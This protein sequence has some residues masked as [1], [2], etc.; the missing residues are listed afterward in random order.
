MEIAEMKQAGK[1]AIDGKKAQTKAYKAKGAALATLCVRFAQEEVRIEEK[2]GQARIKF[3]TDIKAL[4]P[5][6]H[7]EFRAQLR[8]ELLSLD[9]G[10]E[11]L[12]QAG[13]MTEKESTKGGYSAASFRVM[14]SNWMTISVACEAGLDVNEADGTPMKWDTVLAAARKVR[15]D[16]QQAGAQLSDGQRAQG[17]GRKPVS[18]YDKA[19]KA[20]EKLDKRAKVKLLGVLAAALEYTVTA[21]AA[22]PKSAGRIAN[23]AT[24]APATVH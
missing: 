13:A 7:A 19:L 21:P 2:R 1:G 4:T 10:E 22:A 3:V 23:G 20:I 18:D 24:Q 11:L 17:A 6:G 16:T 12:V 15:K 5:E 9:E 8:R 14:V